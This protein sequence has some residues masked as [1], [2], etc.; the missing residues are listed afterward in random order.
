[1][2]GPGLPPREIGLLDMI[3]ELS[4]PALGKWIVL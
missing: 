2:M 3:G 1:M 4:S